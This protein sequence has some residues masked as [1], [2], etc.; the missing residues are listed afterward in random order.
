MKE[1]WQELNAVQLAP[2][3]FNLRGLFPVGVIAARG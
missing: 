1:Q 2:E 3:T